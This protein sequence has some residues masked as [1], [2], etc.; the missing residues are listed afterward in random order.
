MSLYDE[1][2]IKTTLL[3]EQM[4][5]LPGRGNNRVQMWQRENYLQGL[6]NIGHL[7]SMVEDVV[8]PMDKNHKLRQMALG[9]LEGLDE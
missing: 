4:Y 2:V 8:I 5:P 9:K 1:I 7:H 6:I 3:F